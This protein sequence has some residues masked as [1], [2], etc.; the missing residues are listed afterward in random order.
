MNGAKYVVMRL[1]DVE[2]IFTFPKSVDHDRMKEALE[3]IR[4]GDHRNWTRAYRDGEVVSA[5]FIDGGQC[6][7]RSETLNLESRPKLDTALL[8]M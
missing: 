8:N 4:F 6:H 5:G 1:N 2:T 3:C 7:G